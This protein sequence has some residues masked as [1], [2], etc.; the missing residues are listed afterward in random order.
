MAL[1]APQ[2]AKITGTTLT[3]A[4]ADAAGDTFSPS[5]RTCL[6]VRNGS[7]G[8]ITATVTTPGN[9]RY[10]QADPDIPVA[11]PAG[12]EVAVGPFPAELGDPTTGL[13]SVGYSAAASVTVAL[14]SV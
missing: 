9:T 11:V 6:H 2:T 4:A 12:G 7:A 13:I 1:L 3:Y 14:V 5:G 8:A 10:G